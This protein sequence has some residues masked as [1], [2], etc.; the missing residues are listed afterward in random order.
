MDGDNHFSTEEKYAYHKEGNL[1]AYSQWDNLKDSIPHVEREYNRAGNL[2]CRIRF[3]INI[4]N[5]P[6]NG[7]SNMIT[8][9]F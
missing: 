2:V 3:M 7:H 9:D 1:S 8:S 5:S 4:P 6:T